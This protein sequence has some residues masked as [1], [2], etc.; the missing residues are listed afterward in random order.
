MANFFNKSYFDKYLKNQGYRFIE[1][2]DCSRFVDLVENPFG[3]ITVIKRD[4]EYCSDRQT[5][6]ENEIL[7]R[8]KGLRGLPNKIAF[9][10]DILPEMPK[11][12]KVFIT[13][14]RDYFLEE[15]FIPGDEWTDQQLSTA[16]EQTLIDLVNTFHKEGYSRM[17]LFE[18]NF[19]ITFN[20]ELYYLDA[21]Y[22]IK[23]NHPDFKECVGL[24]MQRLER[25]L[26]KSRVAQGVM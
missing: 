15:Q 8:L 1:N 24:D 18:P 13:D 16:A 26:K 6:I 11:K 17:D 4:K 22:C 14:V 21:G 9:R 12:S 20:K 19:R 5:L 7:G 23:K 3:K 10:K 25:L 2:M